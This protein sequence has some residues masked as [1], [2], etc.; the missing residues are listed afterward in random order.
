MIKIRQDLLNQAG[1]SLR[2]CLNTDL[3]ERGSGTPNTTCT[4]IT[5][6][7]WT[8]SGRT[9]I[10]F[11][12]P[13]IKINDDKCE[14]DLLQKLLDE[15]EVSAGTVQAMEGIPEERIDMSQMYIPPENRV[16]SG[17]MD[18][19]DEGITTGGYYDADYDEDE[20]VEGEEEGEIVEISQEELRG[21]EKTGEE[22]QKS[23]Q[24]TD[25]RE[26]QT[27]NSE[28]VTNLNMSSTPVP[29][30]AFSSWNN[31]TIRDGS[32]IS[33]VSTGSK[34]RGRR[35]GARNRNRDKSGSS[36][37]QTK[38]MK[39]EDGNK[40]SAGPVRPASEKNTPA[41]DNMYIKPAKLNMNKAASL[42]EGNRKEPSIIDVDDTC[43]DDDDDDEGTTTDGMST[44][45]GVNEE[46]EEMDH[47]PFRDVE[48]NTVDYIAELIRQRRKENG[49]DPER[50]QKTTGMTK[51]NFKPVKWSG[52][53][54]EAPRPSTEPTLS[55]IHI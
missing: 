54:D 11:M 40:V 23:P 24:D 38:F 42:G 20:L 16:N 33:A 41:R 25:P 4:D 48:I 43:D 9:G 37:E 34:K 12:I 35:G 31:R 30:G 5:T 8:E 21:K 32:E 27:P 49:H 36:V 28:L 29:G 7:P 14:P 13:Q 50:A 18:D 55:L 53:T 19:C 52:D 15:T 46:E 10:T 26:G 22:L 39:D 17:R 3:D 44:V 45:E 1:E 2:D 51:H 47:D 6:K